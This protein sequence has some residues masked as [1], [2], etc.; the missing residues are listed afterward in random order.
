MGPDSSSASNHIYCRS[1]TRFRSVRTVHCIMGL[2]FPWSG[3]IYIV[4]VPPVAG[5]HEQI[6]YD[7][8][9]SLHSSNN[10][11]GRSEAL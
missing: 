8:G 10:D 9:H 4:A 7:D 5:I 11:E 1:A 3:T 2:N 6:V